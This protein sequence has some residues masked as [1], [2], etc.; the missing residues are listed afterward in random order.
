MFSYCYDQAAN[1]ALSSIMMSHRL[2]SAL[3]MELL[4]EVYCVSEWHWE[5]SAVMPSAEPVRT[6]LEIEIL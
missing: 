5:F 2:F 4:A 1:P 6:Y 3:Q